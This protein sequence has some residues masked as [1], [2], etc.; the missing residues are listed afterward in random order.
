VKKPNSTERKKTLQAIA[1]KGGGAEKQ[2]LGNQ[3]REAQW[4]KLQ[5]CLF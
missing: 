5:V 4:P 1:Q 3:L 2:K